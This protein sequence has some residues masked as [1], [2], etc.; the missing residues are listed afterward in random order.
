M[1]NPFLKTW[2]RHRAIISYVHQ[3]S[4]ALLISD[5]TNGVF[6][7]DQMYKIYW[8]ENRQIWV[9]EYC[10]VNPSTTPLLFMK[11]DTKNVR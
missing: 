1:S 8:N 5:E 6:I 7:T 4:L 10:Q 3:F 11:K 2:Y 9:H